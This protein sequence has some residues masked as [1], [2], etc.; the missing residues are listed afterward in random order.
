MQ[1]ILQLL[2]RYFG[3]GMAVRGIEARRHTVEVLTVDL[4]ARKFPLAHELSHQRLSVGDGLFVRRAQIE[5]VPPGD[6]L[7]GTVLVQQQHV[8]V[9]VQQIGTGRCGQ[10]CEP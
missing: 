8:G 10:R 9:I 2:Y 4:K 7:R 6:V 5:A 1:E 3:A